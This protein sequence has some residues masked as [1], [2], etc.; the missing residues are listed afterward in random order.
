MPRSRSYWLSRYLSASGWLCGHDELRHCRTLDDIRIWLATPFAGA[1]E[2]AAAPYWRLLRAWQ[3]DAHVVVLRRPVGE[4]LD[5]YRRLGLPFDR[6]HLAAILTQLAAKLE[7][8]AARWPGVLVVEHAALAEES[9]CAAVF[10]HC[11]G[12]LPDP[13][14]HAALAPVNMQT[15]MVAL[16]RYYDAYRAPLERLA[17]QACQR[18]REG[19]HRGPGPDVGG[20]VIR[21][22]MLETF[23]PDARALMRSHCTDVGEHP[24]NFAHK[25]IPLFQ[26]LEDIGALQIMTARSNGRMFGYHVSILSPSLESED[27]TMALQATTFVEPGVPGLALRLQRAAITAARE[28]GVSEMFYRVSHRGSGQRM[29]VLYKRLGAEAFGQ[30]WRLDMEQ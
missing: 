26:R 18:I 19:L 20:M 4:V 23:L 17:A 11:I 30:M 24:D 10:N 8:I 27:V 25:N 14:W 13:T 3:P 9:T 12:Q 5:S 6:P 2:T 29:G 16:L 21:P 15:D 22:E 28:R 1:V 7:Q